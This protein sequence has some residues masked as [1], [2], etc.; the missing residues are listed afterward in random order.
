MLGPLM[1]GVRFCCQLVIQG[2]APFRP[3]LSP[4]LRQCRLSPPVA[5]F[6]ASRIGG[7]TSSILSRQL[8]PLCVLLTLLRSPHGGLACCCWRIDGSSPPLGTACGTYGGLYTPS[9]LGHTQL[10]A[11][12]D[13]CVHGALEADSVS[14]DT[15]PPQRLQFLVAATRTFRMICKQVHDHGA[16]WMHGLPSASGLALLRQLLPVA[17]FHSFST[18]SGAVFF[19]SHPSF[20]SLVG[21][22]LSTA[23]P[24]ALSGDVPRVWPTAVYRSAPLPSSGE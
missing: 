14:R 18:A 10:A 22:R 6:A 15:E 11:A 21:A 3:L 13:R 8:L 12:S 4:G 7:F 23:E 20:V 19:A 5:P 1:R 16:L 2:P 9:T 24:P 17:Q